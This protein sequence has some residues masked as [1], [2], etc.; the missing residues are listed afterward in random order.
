[1]NLFPSV[2]VNLQQPLSHGF[3]LIFLSLLPKYTVLNFL[4]PYAGS[5]SF[6]H[7]SHRF[8]LHQQFSKQKKFG[9]TYFNDNT[10][11]F[12]VVYHVLLPWPGDYFCSDVFFYVCPKSIIA[13]LWA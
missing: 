8:R 5:S 12:Q 9:S 4:L 10:I 1:M 3:R 11:N 6:L 13:L 7:S 2:S